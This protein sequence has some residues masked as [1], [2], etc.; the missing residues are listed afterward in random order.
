[1]WIQIVGWSGA[2]LVILAYVLVT[3]DKIE[4][5]GRLYQWLNLFGAIGVGIS[6]FHQKAWPALAIQAV[7]GVVALLALLS[8]GKTKNEQTT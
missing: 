5:E 6:V 2:V 7:W 4:G 8:K 3:S 1:M